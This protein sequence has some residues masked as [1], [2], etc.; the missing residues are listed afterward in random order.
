MVFSSA[1]H[2]NSLLRTKEYL[3]GSLCSSSVEWT[4]SGPGNTL[5]TVMPGPIDPDGPAAPDA[6]LIAVGI[7]SD[8]Q[9]KV[10]PAGNWSAYS[11]STYS[12]EFSASKYTFLLTK[13]SMYLS[14]RTMSNL[15]ILTENDVVFLPDFP[16]AVT[17]LK[18]FQNLTSKSKTNKWLIAQDGSDD[19]IRFSFNVF[20]KKDMSNSETATNIS[21]WPVP[22]ECREALEKIV[23]THVIREFL[24]FDVDGSRVAPFDI[25]SKLQGALVECSFTLGHHAFPDND[26]FSGIIQQ[27]LIL[28]AAQVKPASP[29]KSAT[30][31]YR[32]TALTPEQVHAEQQAVK[33]FTLP[34]S[35][36]GPSNLPASPLKRKASE[37]PEGSKPKR[38]ETVGTGG[39][40]ATK[41]KVLSASTDK[42][43]AKVPE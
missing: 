16:I 41:E 30:K 3:A 19:A 25:K 26:S 42:E 37:E 33:A 38:V 5:T 10:E 36:A 7:V 43:K 39:N 17:A 35:T 15:T 23:D 31:P 1:F 14:L 18:K 28:R 8:S 2:R 20:E 27:V 13:P 34:I 4:R 6:V 9:L 12:K 40:G 24:V 22:T 29:Y 11:L 32:P 21:T